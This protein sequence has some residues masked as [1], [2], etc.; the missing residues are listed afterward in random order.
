MGVEKP[1]EEEKKEK[2]EGGE[3]KFKERWRRCGAGVGGCG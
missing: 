2:A 1:E 3:D